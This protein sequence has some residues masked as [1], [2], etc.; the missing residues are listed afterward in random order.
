MTI[1]VFGRAAGKDKPALVE[2]AGH[3]I[4]QMVDA[5]SD[6]SKKGT[7]GC[8]AA[9]MH[10]KEEE[11]GATCIVPIT[12]SVDDLLLAEGLTAAGGNIVGSKGPWA[13]EQWDSLQNDAEK[14]QEGGALPSYKRTY[15]DNMAVAKGAG[16]MLCAPV[17]STYFF[18]IG[19]TVSCAG[20][21]TAKGTLQAWDEMVAGAQVCVAQLGALREDG[22]VVIPKGEGVSPV[23]GASLTVNSVVGANSTILTGYAF[24]FV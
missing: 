21:E 15:T 5:L 24:A 16:V 19:T 17:G 12:I 11:A 3:N 4:D 14:V 22:H 6:L 8:F 20:D 18:P 7:A 2:E 13:Q 1:L 10:D 23:Q 9:V